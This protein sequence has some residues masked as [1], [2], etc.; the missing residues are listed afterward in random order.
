MPGKAFIIA[1]TAENA[2]IGPNSNTPF[3]VFNAEG[4]AGFVIVSGDDRTK[5]ILG[6]SVSGSFK[7]DALPE[8]VEWWLT[9]TCTVTVKAAGTRSL[10][11]DDDELTDIED[12]EID[13]AVTEPFDVYDLTGRKVL[14]QVTSLDGLPNG[15]YIVNGKKVLKK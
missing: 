10:D 1:R 4:N 2:K 11:G 15:I 12:M 8:N 13:P 6:Y 14:H 5:P 3:Y 9:A 7:E